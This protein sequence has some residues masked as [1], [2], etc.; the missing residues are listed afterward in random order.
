MYVYRSLPGL[1]FI[2]LLRLRPA[3]RG[4]A[5]IQCQLFDYQLLQNGF[6]GTDLYEALSYVW[7]STSNRRS[8]FIDQCEVKV[9]SNLHAVLLHLRHPFFERVLWVD[10]LCINQNNVD[11][12]EK[13]VGAMAMTYAK[14]ACVIVWLG[15]ATEGSN[16]AMED[17][18]LASAEHLSGSFLDEIRREA[19][20]TVLQIPWFECMWV[21]N[22]S[23]L[24]VSFGYR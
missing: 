5:D 3:S 16:Q 15:E 1:G 18:R 19:I 14:A 8:I 2:R 9:T 7:G 12:K 17:I 13:Q 6:E 23:K 21:C 22:Q 11:E 10:A 24:D 4:D 20:V